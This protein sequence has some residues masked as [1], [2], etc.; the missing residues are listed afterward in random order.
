M[1]KS[2]AQTV[3]RVGAPGSPGTWAALAR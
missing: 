2:M 3:A 1:V